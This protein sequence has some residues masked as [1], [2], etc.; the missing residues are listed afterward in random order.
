V[1]GVLAVKLRRDLQSGW[2]RTMLMVIAI[3]V[4]LTV[5]GGVLLAWGIAAREIRDAYAGTEPASATILLARPLPAD[6]MA[7]LAAQARAMPGVI[8]ATGRT[9]FDSEQIQIGDRPVS[10][11]M[12]VFV[13]APDDPMQIAKFAV[14]QGSWPPG[15]DEILLGR[16]SLAL[17]GAKVGDVVTIRLPSGAPARKRVAGIVYDPSL[18]PATQHQTAHGYLSAAALTTAGDR[19]ELDQLKLLVAE[20]GT[21]TPT[22][23]RDTVVAAA[24]RVGTWLPRDTATPVREIQVPDPYTHPHQGQTN[25]LLLSLVAGGAAA[26]LLSAVLVANMLNTLFTQQIPQIGIMKAI[27][28]PA[29]RVA[30][31]Y[32]SLIVLVAAAATA[33]ALVPATLLGRAL[34]GVIFRFLGIEPVSLD[35]PWWGYAAMVAA[36]LLLPPVIATVPL[37]RAGRITVRAAIDHHGGS[38]TNPSAA[39]GLLTRLSRIGGRDR[40]LLMALRNTIR[41]PARFVLSVALLAAAGTVFVAG[42][43]LGDGTQAIAD[44]AKAQRTWDVDVQLVDP[45]PTDQVDTVLSRV[46]GISRVDGLDVV[47][48]GVA[49]PGG[50][51]LTHTYPDQGHGSVSLITLPA[52]PGAFTPPELTDGRWLQPGETGAVVLNQITR[53][54]TVP[55][56]RVGDAVQL[57]ADG[58]PGTWRVVGLARERQAA[59]TVYATAAGYAAATAGPQRVN[60]L[61]IATAA[62]NEHTRDTVAADVA[63]ALSDARIAVESATSAS[64]D[65]TIAEGHLSP[66][67]GV[68]IAIAIALAVIGTIG[69]ASTMSANVLDRTRE[70][71]VLHAIGAPPRTVRRIVVAEA[72]FIALASAAAVI[73]PALALTWILGAGLGDLFM[74]APLPHR[75][76]W[77]AALAWSA[78]AIVAAVLATAASAARAG[79][80]TVREALAYL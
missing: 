34:A 33:V 18:A 47:Q 11:P 80:I 26:L 14:V 41:R 6:R 12:Q 35:A 4:S 5:F 22:H 8:A 16:D 76:S 48:V 73:A 32:L 20:P 40:G 43:S 42:I 29:G 15:P 9:Q 61:R 74:H 17:L 54:N 63:R 13:A 78:L 50:L 53:I 69:L 19:A 3:A 72:V 44:D 56:V 70:F 49:G 58:K 46:A 57:F 37:L 51:P 27:G 62:H 60:T 67:I 77:S 1:T 30:R 55:D 71:G 23:Q 31:F 28:A 75:F 25:A 10:H 21:A 2:S 52:D 7:E 45:T 64:R 79:R 68:I 36:G 24:A 59:G 65:D 66:I 38:S 39:T